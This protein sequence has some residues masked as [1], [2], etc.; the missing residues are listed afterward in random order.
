MDKKAMRALWLKTLEKH[1]EAN[2]LQ[3]PEYGRVNE[4]LGEKVVIEDF[5][6]RGYAL[7]IVRNAKR[8]RYLEIPCGPLMDFSN[9]KERIKVFDRITEVAERE[10]CVF[11]RMRP[12]LLATP[13]NL[14]MLSEMGLKKSPMHLA[15]EH[16]VMINLEASEEALLVGMR[17]Q[18][19]YEVRRADKLGSEVLSGNSEELFREFHEVQTETARRQNFVPPSLEVLLAEREAFRN[20]IKIRGA[21]GRGGEDC[22]WADYPGRAGGGL[23]RG[24]L[25]GA[26]SEVAGGVCVALAGDARF[27]GGG[28]CAV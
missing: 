16:T 3:S 1:P 5:G 26:K 2:F 9:L 12:Q 22:V 28:V 24:G 8:G 27:E 19:R 7:M 13:E 6:G 18:T 10:K 15:A 20:K 23:L 11:V 4:I 14:E 21:D 17:R 25:D